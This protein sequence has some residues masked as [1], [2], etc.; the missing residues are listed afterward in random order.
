MLPY[1]EEYVRNVREAVE[2]SGYAQGAQA[3]FEQWHEERL[4]ANA[5]IAE[6]KRRNTQLL[7]EELFPTLDALHSAPQQT[8]DELT[9]VK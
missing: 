2:L 3:P 7:S 8:L 1:Q 4:R 6:L 5:R 9:A